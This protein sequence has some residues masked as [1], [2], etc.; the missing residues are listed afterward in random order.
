MDNFGGKPGKKL[1]KMEKICNRKIPSTMALERT[2]PDIRRWF[3]R[4][5]ELL[6]KDAAIEDH[7]RISVLREV[8]PRGVLEYI[9]SIM[10]V[11]PRVEGYLSNASTVY[12]TK[13]V[14]VNRFPSSLSM[15]SQE[16]SQE[17][18][19]IPSLGHSQLS[20]KTK[21]DRA[22]RRLFDYRKIVYPNPYIAFFREK[23]IL[24]RIWRDVPSL[25]QEKLSLRDKAD[26]VSN[27][28]A[29]EFINWLRENNMLADKLHAKSLIDMFQMVNIMDVSLKVCQEECFTV[30]DSVVL[31]SGET[32]KSLNECLHK[33]LRRD[34]KATFRKP[35]KIAFGKTVS[36]HLQNKPA[37]R[38]ELDEWLKRGNI[39]KELES[40]E[41]VWEDI[42]DLKSTR[43]F[44]HFF[45][46]YYP[47]V[48]PPGCL[49][50]NGLMDPER[51]FS[52]V[53]K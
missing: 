51:R 30:P 12:G 27:R 49:L 28:I 33:E 22:A 13:T 8:F 9:I 24:S 26:V 31:F 37:D 11:E 44:C 15:D 17:V 53:V 23:N 41:V 48:P 18:H 2:D 16:S 14:S 21:P 47:D 45:N 35:K 39:P 5:F 7:E 4:L 43:E 32:N 46:E 42:Y 50:D 38:K 3:E 20:S 34:Y 6:E 52:K 40:M 29:S 25:L 19:K 1:T 10:A 36:T